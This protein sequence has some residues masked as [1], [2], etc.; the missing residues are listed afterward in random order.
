MIYFH[1]ELE[2]RL[3]SDPDAGIFVRLHHRSGGYGLVSDATG[4]NALAIGYRRT[5]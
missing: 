5:F 1:I 2:H 4:T 3:R